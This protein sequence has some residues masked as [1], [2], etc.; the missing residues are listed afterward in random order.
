MTRTLAALCVAALF[1]TGCAYVSTDQQALPG[2]FYTDMTSPGDFAGIALGTKQGVSSAESYL[3]AVALGDASINAA[4]LAGGLTA[5]SHVDY[6]AWS[7]AGFYA[8]LETY[9]YGK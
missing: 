3:G 7:V 8:K 5:V 2:L 1:S 6:H 4:A 9:A